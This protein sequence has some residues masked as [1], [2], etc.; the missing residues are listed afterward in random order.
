MRARPTAAIGGSSAEILA[1]NSGAELGT[2]GRWRL[3]HRLERLEDRGPQQPL[4]SLA[5]RLPI[6][7]GHPKPLGAHSIGEFGL[8]LMDFELEVR[9]P[10]HQWRNHAA[11]MGRFA[12]DDNTTFRLVL[13]EL[14]VRAA[15]AARVRH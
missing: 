8:A 5:Q 10:A 13:A 7:R 3:A 6:G 9:E 11:G 4:A 2:G 1:V 15:V 12:S 14:H